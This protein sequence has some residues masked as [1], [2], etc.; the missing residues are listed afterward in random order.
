MFYYYFNYDKFLC[1]LIMYLVIFFEKKKLS[2]IK[3]LFE[4]S[5]MV[6]IRLIVFFKDGEFC[7]NM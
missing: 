7:I 2:L 3:I 5:W 1:I 6:V 4:E